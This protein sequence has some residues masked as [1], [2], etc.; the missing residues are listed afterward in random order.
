MAKIEKFCQQGANDLLKNE[1]IKCEELKQPYEVGM[2][3]YPLCCNICAKGR[4]VYLN[5][6]ICKQDLPSN[7]TLVDFIVKNEFENCCSS[8]AAKGLRSTGDFEDDESKIYE[9]LDFCQNYGCDHF[10][11]EVDYHQAL[12]SCRNGFAL[13]ADGKKCDDIDECLITPNLCLPNQK[14]IN[15]N[16]T[17]DCKNLELDQQYSIE[18]QTNESRNLN[19]R[20][21][22]NDSQEDRECK[23]G[24]FDPHRNMCIGKNSKVFILSTYLK[25]LFFNY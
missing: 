7:A 13:N 18:N 19:L 6:G 2:D 16:G 8:T 9:N 22:F 3:F 14:C 24:Y 10:C 4:E 25:V 1:S 23:D 11:V 15:L 5:G 20:S 21:S 12:C 17:Y